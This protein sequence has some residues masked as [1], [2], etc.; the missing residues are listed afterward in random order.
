MRGVDRGQHKN[1]ADAIL[2]AHKPLAQWA[3]EGVLLSSDLVPHLLAPLRLE[4]GSA[5]VGCSRWA[6]GWKAISEGRQRLTRVA[7][8]IPDDLLHRGTNKFDMT[9]VPGGD[10]QLVVR[11]C[12][13][14]RMLRR[15]MSIISSCFLPTFSPVVCS[16]APAR[17]S[18]T[19]S[20]MAAI[21]S[22]ASLTTAPRSRIG[23]IRTNPSQSLC[24]PPVGCSAACSTLTARHAGRDRRPRRPDAAALPPVWA[25]NAPWCIR[26]DC[27]VGKELFVC[28][29]GNGRLQVF[30]LAGVHRR[31]I[32]CEWNLPQALCFVKDRLYLVEEA[33][34]D[35]DEEG[36]LIDPQQGRRI[37]VL[38]L[39]GETLQVYTHAYEGQFFGLSAALTGSCWRPSKTID[40]RRLHG[41]S[42]RNIGVQVQSLPPLGRAARWRCGECPGMLPSCSAAAR[43]VTA[44]SPSCRQSYHHSSSPAK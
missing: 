6:E 19:R 14:V 10:E 13:T 38:S 31:S 16:I 41:C 22:P 20:S 21:T 28:D 34:H 3:V 15:D 43:A 40:G 12:S 5:A 1:R 23:R 27:R 30:S 33:E 42:R 18:F 32:T 2:A 24:S 44:C 26:I 35:E 8:D 39:Q 29:T 17:S 11:S 9:V 7:L 4:D 25:V 36:E 37:F